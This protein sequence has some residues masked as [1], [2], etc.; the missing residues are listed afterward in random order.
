[1]LV[2]ILVWVIGQGWLFLATDVAL[3]RWV[4]GVA[5]LELH[6]FGVF[7]VIHGTCLCSCFMFMFY[8]FVTADSAFELLHVFG[9]TPS[10]F[11]ELK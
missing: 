7:D 2:Y 8:V 9:T 5:M 4:M 3:R 10:I 11:L 6:G 1:M